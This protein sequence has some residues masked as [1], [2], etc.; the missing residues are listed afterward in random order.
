MPKVDLCESLLIAMILR[1]DWQTAVNATIIIEPNS[2]ICINTPSTSQEFGC[3][4]SY[5]SFIGYVIQSR[6]KN[7]PLVTKMPIKV[8]NN[9][10]SITGLKPFL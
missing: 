2:V 9:N 5:N 6:Y 3:L 10:E 1:R 7:K 4:K 8:E